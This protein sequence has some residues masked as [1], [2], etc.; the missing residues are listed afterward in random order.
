MQAQHIAFLQL[1][2]GDVQYVVPRWQRRYC[3]DQS[4]IE[5]LVKDL[6]TIA[7]A[8][9]PGAAHYGG[10]LLTFPEPGAAGVV[11]THRVVDGQQRLTTVS[12]LLAC[13]A[14]SLGPRGRC[15]D[16]TA[17]HIRN[18]LTNPDLPPEKRRKLR[19]Q[20]GDEDEYRLGLK[21]KPG[22]PGAVAQAWRIARRLVAQNDVAGLLTGIE[23]F[24]VV[25][26]ALGATDDPQQ[27]FESLNATGRP[28]TESEK[29]KNW[30]LMGLPDEEQQDLHDNYWIEIEQCLGVELTTEPVDTFLR[31]VLRLRTGKNLGIKRVHEELRRLAVRQGQDRDRPALCRELARLA[32]LYGILTGTAGKHP[33]AKVER[34]LRHLRAMGIHTHRPLTLRLL[35]DAAKCSHRD[36]TDDAL[37]KTLAAIG[38]WITR[39]WLA[40][41][42]TAGLNTAATEFAHGPGP[43]PGKDF[44]KHWLA[45]FR[46]LRNTRVGVPG[47][48]EVREGI[49]NRKAYG[50]T[51]TRSSFAFLCALME[52]EHREEAPARK[53]LTIEHVMPRKLTDKW[54]RN[55]GEDAEDVHGLYRDLLPNLTLSGD[56]TNSG[57]GA[58]AFAAKRKVYAKSTIGMTRR[59]AAESEWNEEA[60]GR[61]ADDLADR[62]LERWPWA[63]QA[64]SVSRAEFRWRIEGG[65]WRPE[66][67]ASRMVLNVVGALLD[68]DPVNAEKLSGDSV[69]GNVH[70]ASQ[71]PPG[72]KVGALVLRAVPGH[73]EYVLYPY[74]DF[75]TLEKFCRGLGKRCG[76]RVEVLRDDTDQS[77]AFTQSQAFWRFFKERAGGVPGQ[78]NA[79]RFATQRTTPVNPFGDTI[80]IYIGKELLRLDITAGKGPKS[81]ARA[82]RMR[83]CSRMIRDQMNDQELSDDPKRSEEGLTASVQRSWTRDDDSEWAEAARW[84]RDQHDRLRVIASRP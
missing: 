72:K 50:G 56:A 55:L 82:A 1:L 12:I 57:M 68:R 15:G 67:V 51:A 9:H 75:P 70:P 47:D 36:A 83:D 44:A 20:D 61:R 58:G 30:L 76:V 54:K 40:N 25:S 62:A 53:D 81:G 46:R 78:K 49:R 23:R 37:S 52:A 18:R 74:G 6:M 29:V 17:K 42:A 48:E 63:D 5:R 32:R 10:A 28:L 69:T 73:D 22:G 19:L 84:I 35:D 77:R 64:T 11:T 13:I 26:I 14:D 59:L 21:G 2:S 43:D 80:R 4:D 24:R 45:R 65:A 38:T 3:W 27:I 79:W 60:L 16:W 66:T 33:D 41:R 71:Y 34:E 7:K 8:D 31:D 39:L